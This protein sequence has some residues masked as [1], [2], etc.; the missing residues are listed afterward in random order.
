MDLNIKGRSALITGA[1]KG[2]GYSAAWSLAREGCNVHIASRTGADLGAA[3][4]KLDDAFD[5]EVTVHVCDLSDGDAARALI[6]SCKGVDILVN[7]AGAI[8]AGS[9]HD[10]DEARWRDAWNLKVFGYQNTCRAMLAHMEPRNSG[11][12]VNVVGAAGEAPTPN[13]IAGSAGNASIMALT[14]ALGATSRQYGVRVVGINPGLIVTDRMV[15]LSRTQ[16]EKRFGDAERWRE[17][18]DQT[19]PPGQPEHIGDMVA[20]LASDLSGNTT[21][22]IITIDGG[23]S[24]RGPAL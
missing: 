16:A 5:V 7:N 24:V 3:K 17:T 20:F 8:P 12:I 15:T 10:I 21:G 4:A 23:A 22:T 9:I 18:L 2:I 6:E 1:S 19:Y 11:V 14:R 13:Y